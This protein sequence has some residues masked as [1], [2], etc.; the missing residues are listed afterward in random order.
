MNYIFCIHSFVGGHLSGFLLLTITNT[1]TMNIVEHVFLWY[2]GASSGYIPKSQIV[3]S[4]GRTIFNF[5]RNCKIDFQSGCTSLHSCQ[6][7]RSVPLALYP[8]LQ[9]ASFE[10]LILAILLGIKW[11]LKDILIC[12]SLITNDWP[13]L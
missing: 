13:F 7:W 2:G 1:A 3:E 12:I 8:I 6:Q 4:L 9:L 10:F 5:L 11:N